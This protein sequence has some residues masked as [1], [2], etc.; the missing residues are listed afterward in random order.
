MMDSIL[1]VFVFNSALFDDM[2]EEQK[3][4]LRSF[5]LGSFSN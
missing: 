2:A 4:R 1:V 3:L 5:A